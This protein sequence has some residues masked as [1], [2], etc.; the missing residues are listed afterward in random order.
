MYQFL[1][2]QISHSRILSSPPLHLY[3]LSQEHR[4]ECAY[5][6][7]PNIA[8]PVSQSKVQ[9]ARQIKKPGSR[10]PGKSKRVVTLTR[11]QLAEQRKKIRQTRKELANQIGVAKVLFT[12]LEARPFFLEEDQP[13]AELCE[14]L[15][16]MVQAI[17]QKKPG[18]LR[19]SADSHQ[20]QVRDP[21][22]Q[23]NNPQLSKG[24]FEDIAG[25]K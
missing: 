15:R 9:R 18:L 19:E 17:K 10:K 6:M 14:P 16:R 20:E 3:R 25:G 11:G 1:Q 23:G 5:N 8:T 22:A 24:F 7:D 12:V 21:L 4:S 13:Y 2:F